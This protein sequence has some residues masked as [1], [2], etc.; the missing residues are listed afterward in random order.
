MSAGGYSQQSSPSISRLQDVCNTDIL[1]HIGDASLSWDQYNN[2]IQSSFPD[3]LPLES[4]CFLTSGYP[5]Y[6]SHSHLQASSR[7]LLSSDQ[8]NSSKYDR[9][10]LSTASHQ[11]SDIQSFFPKPI[12]S[13]SILIF[14]ALKNSKT[15]SLPVSEIYSFMT[16]H[17]PYFKTAP[18]GWKN[19]VRHNLSLN[20]CFEKV[21]NKNGNTSRKGCLWTLNPAKVEKMQEELHKW[22]RKDPINM[23]RSMARPEDF[24]QLL[25]EKP[26]RLRSL[27]T[28]TNSSLLSRVTPAHR[29]ISSSSIPSHLRHYKHLPPQHHCFPLT[30][31]AASPSHSFPLCSPCGQQ[32]AATMGLN[33]PVAG[34][35]PPVFSPALQEYSTGYRGVQDLLLE[36]E[37]TYDIDTLNPSLTDLQLQGKTICHLFTNVWNNDKAIITG[38]HAHSSGFKSCNNNN[39]NN[40]N[41]KNK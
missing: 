7:L 10:N 9:Q 29:S 3:S 18:D 32:Y 24:E 1:S 8:S 26:E 33:S 22:R 2:N 5:P 27:Q 31:P 23:R 19:S 21:E 37:A 36:G 39:N 35:M 38:S 30:V 13:Y 15:G 14:L 12:Y 25:G 11:E 17:F 41:N 40:N 34:T 4:A 16:E 6:T 28:Y 20:K